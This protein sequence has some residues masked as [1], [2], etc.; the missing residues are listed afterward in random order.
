MTEQEKYVLVTGGTGYIGSHTIVKLLKDGWRVI[1][2]DN[3]INSHQT[4]ISK[5]NQLTEPSQ[6][7]AFYEVDLTDWEKL[8]EVLLPY[9]QKLHAVIHFAGS[10]IFHYLID[11]FS[12]LLYG[13]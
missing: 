6:I 11:H 9:K 12:L 10:S 4:V 2:I 3:L 8:Q 7:S 5:V 1:V 13:L